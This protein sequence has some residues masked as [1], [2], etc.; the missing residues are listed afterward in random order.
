M[1][2]TALHL[3]RLVQIYDTRYFITEEYDKEFFHLE[4]FRLLPVQVFWD[5]WQKYAF[6]T[7]GY[8]LTGNGTITCDEMVRAVNVLE[9]YYQDNYWM[10]NRIA[11]ALHNFWNALFVSDSTLAFVTLMSVIETFTNLRKKENVEDQL[12]RNALKL[13]PVDGNGH[14]VTKERLGAMYDVRS[15][16]SHGSYGWDRMGRQ[17]ATWL[18]FDLH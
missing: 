1:I 7:S 15:Y 4:F 17:N 18:A 14:E 3:F 12:F 10:G 13:V 2:I 5:S 8:N 11:V 16:L 6:Q 9:K